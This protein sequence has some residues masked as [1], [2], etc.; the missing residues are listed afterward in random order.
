[1]SNS[2]P[3]F[4][5]FGWG[6]RLAGPFANLPAPA[7]EPAPEED[8]PPSPVQSSSA[9]GGASEPDPEPAVATV[10]EPEGE[11][12]PIDLPVDGA[13]DPAPDLPPAPEPAEP[14]R[15]G[16]VLQ[17]RIAELSIL[18]DQ[19]AQDKIAARYPPGRIAELD[20]LMA[21]IDR[22]TADGEM[23]SA[24]EIAAERDWHAYGAFRDAVMNHAQSLKGALMIAT[25]DGLE[26][27]A[28][29]LHEGWPDVAD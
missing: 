22:K 15:S 23:P 19:M 10:P 4:E 9:D 14:P 27:I 8:A 24:E 3:Q 1:M 16:F 12:A 18:V 7:P 20:A 21:T 5:R 28:D 11:P 13:G 6:L 26:D 29:G 2:L 17:T 25:A